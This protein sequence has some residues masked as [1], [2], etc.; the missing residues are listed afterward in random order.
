MT[1]GTLSNFAGSG[2]LYTATF[3]PTAGLTGAGTVT[4]A[5]GKFTDPAGNANVATTLPGGF[6]IVA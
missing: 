2:T 4:V 1:G 6:T 3:T 5:A